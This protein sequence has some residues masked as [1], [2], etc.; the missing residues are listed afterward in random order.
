[1][2][3]FIDEEF[4]TFTAGEDG[5][6]ILYLLRASLVSG[7]KRWRGGGRRDHDVLDLVELGLS[8]FDGVRRR[9][10][11][12]RFLVAFLPSSVLVPLKEQRMR[13]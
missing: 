11:D 8:Y 6:D 3:G 1:M 12:E 4:D 2:I 10:I 7:A 13:D 5:V 9:R